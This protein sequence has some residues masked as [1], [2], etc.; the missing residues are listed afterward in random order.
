MATTAPTTTRRYR[1]GEYELDAHA[2]ELRKRGLRIRLHGQPLQVL[3]VLLQNAGQLVT[4]EELKNQLWAADTFV[5]FDHSLHNAIARIREALGDSAEKPRYI[6]TLPRKGY[7]FIAQVEEFDARAPELAT[8]PPNQIVKTRSR[9]FGFLAMLL[10]IAAG[11]SLWIAKAS[12]RA[13]PVQI[14][15]VAVLPLDNLS[16][17]ASQ[18]YFADAMTDELITNLAKIGALR[19]TSRTTVTLYKHTS[20]TLPEIARELNVDG[21]VEGSIVR[22]GQHVRVTA[23]LILASSDQHLWADTYDRNLGDALNLQNEIAGSIAQQV[24]AQLTSEQQAQF[25]SER[26]I[27][28]EAYDA[29]LRGRYHLYNESFTDPVTLN[30]AKAAFEEAIRR[31]SSFSPA[32]SG[33]AETYICLVLFDP[34]EVSAPEGFRLAREAI[35]KALDLDPNNGEAY[36]AL[37]SLTWHADYDWKAADESF[38]KAIALAPSFI[39]AHENR[40]IFL[41]L[42]GR[43]EEALAEVAQSKAIDPGPGSDGAA[44]AVYFQLRDWE[45]LLESSREYLASNPHDWRVHASAGVGYEGIGKLSEAA[46]EYQQAIE[47]SKGDLDS[48]ASLGHVYAVAGRRYDAEKILRNLEQKARNGKASPYLPATVYAGLGKKDKAFELL[49]KAYREKSLDIAWILKP[50]IRTDDLR[51]DAR[52]SDLLNRVGLSQ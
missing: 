15:S 31:D 8:S 37:G 43:R 9:T 48:L 27:D 6:E 20:K 51:S 5:D 24:R 12:R 34:A 23:Q 26:S 38:S 45:A 47:L 13:T 3:A 1:F 2:G 50:D 16:G 17:D 14:R 33:L 42:M 36:D 22:S 10:V 19:V 28:P 4:R 18:D 44:S 11:S 41:A 29:Y 25:R 21:I 35:R 30:R 32:Y 40:A 46:A 52:F 7:R 49:E 39:C